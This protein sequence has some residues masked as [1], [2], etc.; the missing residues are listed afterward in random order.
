MKQFILLS[1]GMIIG[2]TVFSQGKKMNQ[3]IFDPKSNHDI[4]IGYCTLAGIT[5]TLFNSSFKK[6]YDNY[7]PDGE[8]MS[9]VTSLLD[10]ITVT[11]VLGTWCSDSREQVPRFIRIYDVLEHAI[12]F[13]VLICVDS[14]KKAGEV[15]LE[16]MN[17]MKVPTF[18]IYHN[19]RELG[20]I[21]ETPQT[22]L[23]KD[24]L[25]ILRKKL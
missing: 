7:T 4:M 3:T 23:E 16:G 8:I 20:R 6:E 10:E 21:I 1:L 5:D 9:Q 17:I 19:N 14:E 18:I 24:F 13:P 12:P 11:I 22:T 25:T 2:I 15:S